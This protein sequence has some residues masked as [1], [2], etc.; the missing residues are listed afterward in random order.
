MGVYVID[1][2]SPIQLSL[3]I[4]IKGV[5]GS[6]RAGMKLSLFM[7]LNRYDTKLY[8]ELE[9]IRFS[10]YIMLK[11]LINLYIYKFS[12]EFYIFNKVFAGVKLGMNTTKVSY[13]NGTQIKKFKGITAFW[14]DETEKIK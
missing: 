9:A 5:L 4:G 7:G 14:P 11:F 12:I 10:F 6:G 3:S 1:A 2:L 8:F 13:Y